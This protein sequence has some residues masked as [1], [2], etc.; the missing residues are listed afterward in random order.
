MLS[1]IPDGNPDNYTFYKWEH[2]SDFNEHVRWFYGTAESQLMINKSQDR[3]ANEDDGFYVCTVSNGVSNP[4][5]IFCQKGQVHVAAS[6]KSA[7]EFKTQMS[8][9]Y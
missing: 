5:G 4:K 1:C 3:K 8:K 9:I 2:R 7:C 6:G